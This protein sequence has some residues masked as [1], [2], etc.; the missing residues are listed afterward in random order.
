VGGWSASRAEFRYTTAVTSP[1][2]ICILVSRQWRRM[3][4][5]NHG[6]DPDYG[7]AATADLVVMATPQL[8]RPSSWPRSFEN[9]KV[10]LRGPSIPSPRNSRHTSENI[11]L[12][13]EKKPRSC[14]GFFRFWTSDR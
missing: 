12:L 10:F 13:N 6:V 11:S 7:C 4:V 8:E 9:Y 14:R 5:E 2:G 1:P 3:I